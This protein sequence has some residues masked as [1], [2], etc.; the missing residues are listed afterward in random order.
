MS[1]FLVLRE[2]GNRNRWGVMD[3]C[4]QMLDKIYGAL[5]Q[6]ARRSPALDGK[7]KTLS[8]IERTGEESAKEV[9]VER[10]ERR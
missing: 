8:W 2:W 6:T 5:G 10:K 7:E 9:G 1:S 3:K 4:V